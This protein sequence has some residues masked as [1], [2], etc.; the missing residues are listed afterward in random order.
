MRRLLIGVTVLVIVLVA[1]VGLIIFLLP[2]GSDRTPVLAESAPL[3]PATRTSE[4][5]APTAIAL[6]AIRDV[7]EAQAPRDLS[8]K[9]DNPLGQLL[10]NAELGWVIARGPLAL[11][12][13]PEG[14]A[15]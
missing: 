7:M 6:A 5:I 12:G 1:T 8:G 4:V 2:S 13:R 9:R 14:L 3:K 11:A 10:Q 15:I